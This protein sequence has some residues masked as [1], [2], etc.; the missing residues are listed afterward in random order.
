MEES[1]IDTQTADRAGRLLD[2]EDR[3]GA[4]NYHP[5]DVVIERAAGSWVYSVDGDLLPRLPERLFRGQSGPLQSAHSASPARAGVE[6]HADFPRLPQRSVTAVLQRARRAL[7]QGNRLA[8]E[9]RRR[10]SRDGAQGGAAV[11]IHAQ[12]DSGRP[13]RDRR[14]RKQLSRPHYDDRRVLVR[15]R[16]P[17]GFRSLH[18]GFQSHPLRGTPRRWKPSSR[19]TLAHFW[20]SLSSAK[21]EF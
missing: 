17:G 20:W 21:R 4:H 8:H 11:G 9:Y 13:G 12:R 18:A 1:C 6:S 2:I 5:L 3:W 14:L 7:R 15:R 10:S 19:R 16:Q